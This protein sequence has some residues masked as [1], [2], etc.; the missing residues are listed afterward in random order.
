MKRRAGRWRKIDKE[1]ETEREMLEDCAGGKETRIR[2]KR[3]R[4]NPEVAAERVFIIRTDQETPDLPLM[5]LYSRL[6]RSLVP[7]LVLV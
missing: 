3:G 4:E 6:A 2:E 7:T 5:M 1:G